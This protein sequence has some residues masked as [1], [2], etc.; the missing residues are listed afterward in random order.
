MDPYCGTA[1]NYKVRCPLCKDPEQVLAE[2]YLTLSLRLEANRL[3]ER[4][5]F[6][7]E[8]LHL[9]HLLDDPDEVLLSFWREMRNS[10]KSREFAELLRV[11]VKSQDR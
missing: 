3:R 8:S 2:S 11:F 7:S 5:Q 1:R 4:L 6:I 10:G 9:F